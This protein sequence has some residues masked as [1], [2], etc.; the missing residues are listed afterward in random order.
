M[1]HLPDTTKIYLL[2]KQGITQVS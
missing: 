2:N 1:Y